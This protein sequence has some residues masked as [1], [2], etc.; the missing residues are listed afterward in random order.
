MQLYSMKLREKVSKFLEN[1]ESEEL[2]VI[3]TTN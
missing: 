3:A 1:E 2:D